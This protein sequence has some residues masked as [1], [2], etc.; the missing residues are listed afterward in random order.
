[1]KAV[2]AIRQIQRY[3]GAVRNVIEHCQYLKALGYDITVI[4]ERYNRKILD[5]CGA[6]FVRIMRWPIKG[7]YRRTWFDKRV[8]RWLR[9]NPFDLFFSHGDSHSNDILVMHNCVRLHEEKCGTPELDVAAFHD[10]VISAGDYRVLITNSKLMADDFHRRYSVPE[11]KLRVFYQGV[12]TSLFNTSGKDELRRIARRELQIPETST[13]VGLI[14]SGDFTK[15]NVHFFLEIAGFLTANTS[16]PIEFL[17]VGKSDSTRFAEQISAHDLQFRIRFIDPV[18]NVHELFH[19]LDLH[20]FPALLEEYGRVVLEGLACG[21]PTIA[22][23]NVGVAELMRDHSVPEVISGYNLE[24]WGKTAQNILTDP[25]A[26]KR[27]SQ[28]AASLAQTYSMV[29]QKHAMED[30][31]SSLI[32][33]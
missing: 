25:V 1:M 32:T 4:A 12:D 2:I 30:L 20:I 10:S 8:Q 11:E 3:T 19:A 26:S 22:S 23:D 14:T 33:R 17:V 21:V 16:L 6:D 9:A 7:V 15:R 28:A 13:V 27:A 31:L 5:E 18:P 24:D 29:N